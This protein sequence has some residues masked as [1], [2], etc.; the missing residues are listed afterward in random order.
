MGAKRGV[1]YGDGGRGLWVRGEGEWFIGGVA[2]EET[3]AWPLDGN[4]GG[5][6]VGGVACGEWGRGHCGWGRGLWGWGR[7]L[8]GGLSY[9]GG[10]VACREE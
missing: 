6:Q 8:L 2:S 4:E 9:R 3:G 1:A 5:E 10:G 7:G